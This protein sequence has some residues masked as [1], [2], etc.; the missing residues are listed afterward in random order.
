MAE[1]NTE[2]DKRD[3]SLFRSDGLFGRPP[4]RFDAAANHH[5]EAVLGS[6]LTISRTL[7]TSIRSHLRLPTHRHP[8]SSRHA[9]HDEALASMRLQKHAAPAAPATDLV[10]SS[11]LL[12]KQKSSRAGDAARRSAISFGDGHLFVIARY[13]RS[14]FA[15]F[16]SNLALH[17]LIS[18]FCGRIEDLSCAASFLK[19]H[20][21]M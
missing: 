10:S 2:C 14:D 9:A 7:D 18:L 17:R 4:V 12:S 16:G 3:R 19:C 20:C 15:R 5:V 1:P 8:L 11:R 13:R 6:L 21:G